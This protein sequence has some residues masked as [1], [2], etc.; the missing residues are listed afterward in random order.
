MQVNLN[1]AGCAGHILAVVLCSPALNKAHTDGTHLGELINSLKAVVNRLGQQFSKLL[2]V[3]NLQAAA[4]GNLTHSCGMEAVVVVTVTTLDEDTAIT[5]TFCVHLTTNIIQMDTFADV[6]PGVLNG[7]VAVHVGEQAEAESVAVIGGI[8]ET[9][10]EH[11]GGGSLERLSDT[12]VE[13]VVNNRAPV[14]GFLIGHRLH[15][16][17]VV[18][19]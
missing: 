13:L 15:I 1:P 2:V 16:C 17:S 3:E 10:N 9:V 11:A 18:T 7:G 19:L 5:Q 4:A 6:P 12:I 8:C 14:L